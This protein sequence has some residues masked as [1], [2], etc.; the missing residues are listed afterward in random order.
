M[1]TMNRPSELSFGDRVACAVVSAVAASLTVGVVVVFLLV[2]T[3]VWTPDVWSRAVTLGAVLTGT[4]AVGG[5]CLGPER[6]VNFL[7]VVWGTVEPKRWQLCLIAAVVLASVWW[8]A[9]W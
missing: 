4:A 6:M 8:L 9:G 2:Y 7:G 5:F 1:E 3:E